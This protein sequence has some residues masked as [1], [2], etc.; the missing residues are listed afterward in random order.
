[1]TRSRTFLSFILGSTMMTACAGITPE[2][3]GGSD[4]VELAGATGP[5]EEAAETVTE[6]AAW[7]PGDVFEGPYGG[8]PAFDK[9]DIALIEPALEKG[10]DAAQITLKG[11]S[12]AASTATLHVV[13]KA[14]TRHAEALFLTFVFA[15]FLI[16]DRKREWFHGF[17]SG[18]LLVLYGPA[19]FFFDSLRFFFLLGSLNPFFCLN[20]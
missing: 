4:P 10:M 14:P 20:G 19:R 8:V 3:A 1:M 6:K 2:D 17:F 12:P 11:L 16:L 13:G 9:M 5:L 7:S 15:L 18:L